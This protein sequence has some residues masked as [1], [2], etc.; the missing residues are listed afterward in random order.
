MRTSL[1]SRQ[2]LAAGGWALQGLGSAG[3]GAGRALRLAGQPA[4]G[5]LAGCSQ[6]ASCRGRALPT[7]G[8]P[9]SA[10][11]PALPLPTSGWPLQVCGGY[12]D[13]MARCAQLIE[14]SCQVSFVDINFGCPIDLVCRWGA[15]VL[16]VRNPPGGSERER[17][18]VCVCAFNRSPKACMWSV[19][20]GALSLSCVQAG[21][22]P[23]SH[24]PLPPSCL[25]PPRRTWRSKGAGSACL[26]KPQRMEQIVRS[27]SGVLSCPLTFKMRKVGGWV[28]GCHLSVVAGR[29]SSGVVAGR[30]SSGVAVGWAHLVWWLGGAR[31]HT[32][33]IH[34]IVHAPL[35]QHSSFLSI[36]PPP[37]C[38]ATT[39]VRTLP[40]PW[41]PRRRGGAQPPSRCTAAPASSATA[42]EWGAAW[43]G[44]RGQRARMLAC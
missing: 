4:A 38:R 23:S 24:R 40:T 18:C 16:A 11:P 14:D 5:V 8:L 37:S 1:V 13:T 27:M 20:G 12:A 7:V 42:S 26:L 34:P 29:R 44:G 41:C 6:Q 30:R 17:E 22:P 33:H 19:G 15:A 10:P 32:T 36:L 43:A 25:P 9:A 2:V 39:T 21:L 28:G 35:V 3:A 31:L